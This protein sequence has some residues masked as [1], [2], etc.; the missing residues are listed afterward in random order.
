MTAFPSMDTPPTTSAVGAAAVGAVV[1]LKPTATAKSRLDTVPE[2]LRR[3]LAWTMAVDTL[4]ALAA[5]V[6]RVLVVSDEP[7]LEV[8]LQ[9]LGLPVTVVAEP[10]PVGMNGALAYGA[11]QL[12]AA[13][14]EVV[15]ACVGDLPGL[16]PESVRRVLAGSVGCPRAFV[17]DA[18]GVGTTMLVA[19]R[20]ALQPHFQGRSAAAHAES[21]AVGL[22]QLLLGD[23][24]TDARR[25]VDTLSDLSEALRNGL[26]AATSALLDPATDAIGRY[27]MVTVATERQ[28]GPAGTRAADQ[29]AI[30]TGGRRVRMPGAAL[31][32]D[33]LG[34]HPGQR[35][36]AVLADGQVLAA[37]W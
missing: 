25:D 22:D 36:H 1:A 28:D 6:D 19:R 23:P 18:S 4:A 8:R 35:L 30:T 16:R 9:R 2:P 12:V 21:G 13:G 34:A 5:A 27:S 32:A 31:D 15:L 37:W 20:T 26:G 14:C 3:R 29:L 11:E 17:A 10:G 7:T 24:V 33:A